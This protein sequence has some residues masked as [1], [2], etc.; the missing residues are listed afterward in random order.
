MNIIEMDEFILYD[1]KDYNRDLINEDV[2]RLRFRLLGPLDQAYNIN[3]YICK[4]L[5]RVVEFKS[6]T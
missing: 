3:T 1:D 6:Y 2:R 5:S 4:S